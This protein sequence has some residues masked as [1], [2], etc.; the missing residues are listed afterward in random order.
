MTQ[1]CRDCIAGKYSTALAANSSSTCVA[2]PNHTFSLS[3]T[4]NI[5]GCIC[6]QGYFGPDGQECVA[7]A[8]GKFKDVNGSADT[9]TQDCVAC[10]NDT[11]SLAGSAKCYSVTSLVETQGWCRSDLNEYVGDFNSAQEC[12]AACTDKHG[13]ALVAVV[14]YTGRGCYCQDD[15]QCMVGT[16]DQGELV[17]ASDFV[18]PVTC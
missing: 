7:C 6:N 16:S 1:D 5:T 2:C 18:L 9:T 15:C 3:G 12:W 13:K 8:A 4:D 14:W 17:I 10:P 11:F